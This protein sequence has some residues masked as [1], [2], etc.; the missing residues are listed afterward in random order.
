MR[1]QE[2]NHRAAL[3]SALTVLSVLCQLG[4]LWNIV[5][6]MVW[7]SVVVMFA[8]VCT[9]LSFA[10][11]FRLSLPSTHVLYYPQ[12]LTLL[13]NSCSRRGLPSH[14]VF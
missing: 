4:E 3:R 7:Q 13:L 10:A 8:V 5:V 9:H 12:S 2:N 14:D 1:P 6:E 11:G